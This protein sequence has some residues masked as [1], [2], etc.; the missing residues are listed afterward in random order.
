MYRYIPTFPPHSERVMLDMLVSLMKL[1]S[2]DKDAKIRWVKAEIALL[3]LCHEAGFPMTPKF[4]MLQHLHLQM[5]QD[6]APRYAYC[7]AEETKNA[8]LSELA[9]RALNLEGLAEKVILMHEMWAAAGCPTMS[10]LKRSRQQSVIGSS[11]SRKRS[12]GQSA[13]A[14]IVV[15]T[16]SDNTDLDMT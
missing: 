7:F 6:C 1:H 5:E 13:H 11:K 9:K 4:H 3:T 16:D 15:Q 12:E 8:H 10:K 14:D 2:F